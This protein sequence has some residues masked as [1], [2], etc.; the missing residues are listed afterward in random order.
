M[1][2]GETLVVANGGIETHPDSGRAKLNIPLMRPNLAYMGLDGRPRET[3]ELPPELHRNSIRHLAV[4]ADGLVGF[5][6]QWQG[7]LAEAPP[8]VG[9]HR[10]DEAVRL[11]V[12][13]GAEQRAMEG[14]AGSI[15]L[16][17]AT[18]QVAISSPRGGRAQFFDTASGRH[19]GTFL[20]PDICGLAEA[21]DGVLTSAGSG[22]VSLAG[23]EGGRWNRDHRCQW[24]NHLVALPR[25]MRV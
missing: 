3:V 6:M 10:R 24:D 18:G 12:A 21:A 15:A 25:T 11:L 1:P 9:L 7:D 16:S 22:R 4:G 20:G 13:E 2:D 17:P 8:L 5:A 19:V 14:Y 23:P